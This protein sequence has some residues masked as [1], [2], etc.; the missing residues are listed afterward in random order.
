M[1]L[2]ALATAG[3]K[4]K[5]IVSRRNLV[6]W[7]EARIADTLSRDPSPIDRSKGLGFDT[8]GNITLTADPTK[9]GKEQVKKLAKFNDGSI[10]FDE[11]AI[12]GL[13]STTRNE[14]IAMIVSLCLL[15][16]DITSIIIPASYWKNTNHPFHFNER[17]GA[18]IVRSLWIPLDQVSFAKKWDTIEIR[19]I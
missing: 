18:L 15:R 16:E 9:D 5:D 7:F 1:V 3:R 12:D 8:E 13:T 2:H 19:K 6:W 10:I 14:T 4:M 11:K 17:T